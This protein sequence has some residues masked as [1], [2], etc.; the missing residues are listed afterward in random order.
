MHTWFPHLYFLGCETG[1][2]QNPSYIHHVFTTSPDCLHFSTL[3]CLNT[4]LSFSACGSPDVSGVTDSG[5]IQSPVA[6]AEDSHTSVLS[7]RLR[8]DLILKHGLSS[9]CTSP[10]YLPPSSDG[11]AVNQ[12]VKS[13]LDDTTSCPCPYFLV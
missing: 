3:L 7:Y 5:H 12:A 4:Q 1:N 8:Q 9:Y 11:D 6:F 13:V 10:F 2:A